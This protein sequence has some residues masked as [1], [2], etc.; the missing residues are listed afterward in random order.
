MFK[1]I[2]MKTISAGAISLSL[3][4]GGLVVSPVSTAFARTLPTLPRSYYLKEGLNSNT[5]RRSL[6]VFDGVNY[7]TRFSHAFRLGNRSVSRGD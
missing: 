3:L 7:K 1:L 6:L 5:Y 4:L 2:S